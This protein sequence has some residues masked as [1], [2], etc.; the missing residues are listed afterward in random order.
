MNYFYDN[1]GT[2]KQK[3]KEEEQKIFHFQKMSYD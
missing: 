3:K 2:E 1:C